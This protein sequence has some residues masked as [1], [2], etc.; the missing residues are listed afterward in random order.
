M[1]IAEEQGC[2]RFSLEEKC[3]VEPELHPKGC[4][5]GIKIC[6]STPSI[7]RIKSVADRKR[8]IT[9]P[10]LCVLPW[11]ESPMQEEILVVAAVTRK[12][13]LAAYVGFVK[14]DAS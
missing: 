2:T 10:P 11:H 4:P 6:I 14:P 13:R 5:E 3:P 12:N 1:H 8:G 7:I 9:I